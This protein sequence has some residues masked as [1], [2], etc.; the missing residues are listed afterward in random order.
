LAGRAAIV[1]Y[2][3]IASAA[4]SKAGRDSPKLQAELNAAVPREILF[5][6]DIGRRGIGFL[7][8]FQ[9]LEDRVQIGIEHNR[10]VA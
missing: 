5:L 10:S 1:M 7:C 9:G 2:K 3:S 6:L 8:S 4:A